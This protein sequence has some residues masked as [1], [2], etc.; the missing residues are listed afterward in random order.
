[1][2]AKKNY[3][4]HGRT[5]H[6]H[7]SVQFVSSVDQRFMFNADRIWKLVWLIAGDGR[8]GELEIVVYITKGGRITRIA[9]DFF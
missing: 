4:V 3:H 7:P 8:K 6:T 2:D 9:I 5:L 1:M